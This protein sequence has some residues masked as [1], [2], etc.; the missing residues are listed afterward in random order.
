MGVKKCKKMMKELSNSCAC[1]K[2][3]TERIDNGLKAGI[4]CDVCWE[5]LISDCRMRSY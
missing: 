2:P 5:K 3:G 1:G 4:H